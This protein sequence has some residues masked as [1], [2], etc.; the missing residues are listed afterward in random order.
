M[1]EALFSFVDSV[2]MVWFLTSFTA[3]T[4]KSPKYTVPGVLV[5]FAA[6]L[7]TDRFLSG[8]NILAS[9]ILFVLSVVYS[10]IICD[11]HYIK[12]V[13]GS[14]IYKAV[15]ILTSSALFSVISALIDDFGTL[16]Q[17]S[18]STIRIVYVL[19]HKVIIFSVF[20]LVLSVFK[21]SEINDIITGIVVFAVSLLTV[22]GLGCAMVILA[23][24]DKNTGIILVAVFTLINVGM[25]LLVNS[26]IRLEKQRYQLVL[27]N[28]R[29]EFE[30]EKYRE[31]SASLEN[32]KKLRH[33]M[34]NHLLIVKK[35]IENG[36]RSEALRYIDSLIPRAENM[37]G[38]ASVRNEMIDYIINSKLGGLKDTDITV[39][40]VIGDLSDVPE[41]DL[42][43][44]FGN[45]LDNAAEAVEKAD[46][47]RIELRFSMHGENRIFVCKNTCPESLYDRAGI[48]ETTKK[49]KES[50]GIGHIIVEET[51]NRLGGMV[52]YSMENGIF[53]VRMILPRGT[54]GK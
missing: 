25:Y 29:Y 13:I 23:S 54:G 12:A 35:H 38:I 37:G 26:V 5:Y 30:K 43:S 33:D 42:V 22:V 10:L 36:E 17:G 46:E 3:D 49:D 53:E 16:M 1:T 2:I 18:D 15:I 44:L 19:L 48:L 51:V 47:K 41:S 21:R 52:D 11:G 6:T 14:G 7:F 45:I 8:F 24:T 28:E 39:S 40:G 32:A 50:H 34:K 20:S 27:R 4:R 31:T 9:L